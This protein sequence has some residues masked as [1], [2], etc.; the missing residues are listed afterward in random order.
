MYIFQIFLF[1]P[2]VGLIKFLN[3]VSSVVCCSLV[4]SL[5]AIGEIKKLYSLGVVYSCVVHCP[6]QSTTQS[7][8]CDMSTANDR[9]SSGCDADMTSSWHRSPAFSSS[10]SSVIGQKRLPATD[11][12]LAGSA[13]PPITDNINLNRSTELT[14]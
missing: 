9:P 10:S 8:C 14:I 11:L 6:V 4:L 1:F 2:S 7:E 13:L 12:V 5:L 3:F